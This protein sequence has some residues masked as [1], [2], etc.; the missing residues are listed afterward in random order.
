MADLLQGRPTLL[1]SEDGFEPFVVILLIVD[2]DLFREEVLEGEVAFG[3][4][5]GG[6]VINCGSADTFV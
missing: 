3:D 5:F 2:V 6:V 1:A 4:I